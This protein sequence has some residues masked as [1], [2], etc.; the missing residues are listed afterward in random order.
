MPKLK[1]NV[2]NHNTI[3]Y[4]HSLSIIKCL[5][6][7]FR[8]AYSFI[9]I[10]HLVWDDS[11]MLAF[12]TTAIFFLTLTQQWRKF[13]KHYVKVHEQRIVFLWKLAKQKFS[14]HIISL[15]EMSPEKIALLGDCTSAKF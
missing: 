14:P 15:L 9:S 7:K 2:A 1:I 10:L 3:N 11:R 6:S 8:V 12:P 5:F 4:E 13:D